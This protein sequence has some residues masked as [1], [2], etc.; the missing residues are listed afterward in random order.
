MAAGT[1]RAQMLGS[2]SC[3]SDDDE[4]PPASQP[5]RLSAPALRCSYSTIRKI[6]HLLVPDTT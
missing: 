3:Q 2:W 4:R 1:S 5:G 6:V